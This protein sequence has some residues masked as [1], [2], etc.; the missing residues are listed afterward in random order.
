MS[1]SYLK[2]LGVS[3]QESG[4]SREGTGVSREGTG[5]SSWSWSSELESGGVD[6]SWRSGGLFLQLK[7]SLRYSAPLGSRSARLGRVPMGCDHP[8]GA[9][10]R[11]CVKKNS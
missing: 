7:I 6:F 10:T 5:V 4:V 2:G 3:T 11:L 8:Q 9:V 1:S